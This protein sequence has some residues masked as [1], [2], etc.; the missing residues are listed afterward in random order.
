M[1]Q[2]KDRDDHEVLC[3]AIHVPQAQVDVE[4]GIY[5]T[6]VTPKTRA[7]VITLVG[8][9]CIMKGSLDGVKTNLLYD[10]GAQVCLVD[11]H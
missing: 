4:K 3:N 8:K 10:T 7:A 6:R 5:D 1:C 2:K 11:K 9:R